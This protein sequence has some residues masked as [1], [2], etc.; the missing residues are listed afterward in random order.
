MFVSCYSIETPRLLLRSELANS[1]DQ[2]GRNLMTHTGALAGGW[3]A[4]LLG[5]RSGLIV[6]AILLAIA[7]M[8]AAARRARTAP[9][10]IPRP[11]TGR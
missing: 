9:A 1:S 8:V 2:V 5:A 7:A 10:T 6:A 11:D 3:M 4:T